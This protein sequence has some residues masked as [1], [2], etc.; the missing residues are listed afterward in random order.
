M[1]P[2]VWDQR[3]RINIAEIDQQHQKL[4]ELINAFSDAIENGTAD[5]ALKPLFKDLSDY[6]VEHFNTEEKYFAQFNYPLAAAHKREHADLVM[7]VGGMKT[8][9]EAGKDVQIPDVAVFLSAWI[10]RH[11]E[12]ADMQFSAFFRE[13]G[14]N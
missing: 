14:M 1:E 3:Y 8:R 5:E 7:K 13:H 9:L 11:I 12:R 10:T 4:F 2:L 6:A